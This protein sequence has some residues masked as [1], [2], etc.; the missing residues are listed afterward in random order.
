M[1][2]IMMLMIMMF[3]AVAYS[4]AQVPDNQTEQ[5]TEPNENVEQE[6][7]EQ[8]QQ[9]TLDQ[10]QQPQ[11]LEQQEEEQIERRERE[12]GTAGEATTPSGDE[13]NPLQEQD[14]QDE[15]QAIDRFEN[16]E[17]INFRKLPDAVKNS[18]EN[19]YFNEWEV[20]GVYPA[21]EVA[22]SSPVN[23]D[24]ILKVKQS[25]EIMNLYYQSNGQLLM[26]EKAELFEKFIY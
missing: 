7:Q 11:D 10:E 3:T 12:R 19:G 25:D 18:F 4:F 26:Q 21:D 14:Q 8:E 22:G 17:T 6:Q 5:Q 1:K 16:A 15:G 2:R 13:E 24:Y 9:E 23:A 20:V